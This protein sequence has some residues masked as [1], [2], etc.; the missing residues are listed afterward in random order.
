V[1]RSGYRVIEK[2]RPFPDFLA[3][4]D[5]LAAAQDEVS[6]MIHRQLAEP[7]GVAKRNIL[8]L[9]A[10]EPVLATTLR[11]RAHF[12]E[13]A[14]M[15]C[16]PFLE[17]PHRRGH[18]EEALTA[19]GHEV[20]IPAYFGDSTAFRHSGRRPL[21]IYAMP[22]QAEFRSYWSENTWRSVVKTRNKTADLA[23]AVDDPAALSFLVDQWL[24]MWGEDPS[25][26]TGV[27]DDLRAIWPELLARGRLRT[28]T[29]VADGR[30]VA[31]Y[32]MGTQA[33]TAIGLI[34]ARD[35]SWT[36]GSLGI[37]VLVEAM[38]AARAAGFE[39]LEL[40][41]YFEYKQRFAPVSETRYTIHLRPGG[42]ARVESRVRRLRFLA[43]RAR[44]KLRRI[45]TSHR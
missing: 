26:E 20:M 38:Q 10:A 33:N 40:G 23:V 13:P 25:D 9:H 14:T 8:V 34:T 30:P 6:R 45:A 39:S 21:D 27:A 11:L 22:L 43:S 36:R 17:L 2:K 41:G 24:Q 15:T 7:T 42:R 32:A 37:R 28:V 35:R 18:L 3:A 44:L 29:L 1:R 16:A 31:G 12:W 4:V 19:A 5:E